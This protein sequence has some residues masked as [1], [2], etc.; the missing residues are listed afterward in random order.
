MLAGIRRTLR[1]TNPIPVCV[2]KITASQAVSVVQSLSIPRPF[3]GCLIVEACV[4]RAP[5]DGLWSK[6]RVSYQPTGGA[7]DVTVDGKVDS[8]D[9]GRH[10]GY[11]SSLEPGSGPRSL[12]TASRFHGALAAVAPLGGDATL[13]LTLIL[14]ILCVFQM[15]RSLYPLPVPIHAAWGSLAAGVMLAK[16]V[17]ARRFRRLF[18][19]ALVLSTLRTIAG[20][21]VL[22]AFVSSALLCFWWVL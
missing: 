2:R 14:C 1:L 5:R 22:G 8:G 17:I 16:V 11:R 10:A 13:L 18:R 12:R 19:D 9:F 3:Q 6:P 21:Y 7:A 4:E 15:A 20:L